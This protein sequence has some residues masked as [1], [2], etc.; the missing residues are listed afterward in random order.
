MSIL[1]VMISYTLGAIPFGLLLVRWKTGKDVRL[2]GSGRTGTTNSMRAAGYPVGILTLIL[3][4]LK[5]MGT[6][7]L[8]KW[9]APG[10]E[11]A[12]V[13]APLAAILGHNYSIFLAE[14]GADGRVRLR[15][16]A[17]GA[18]ALGGA[19]GLYPLNLVILVGVGLIMFFGVGYASLAT[20]SVGV[21]AT[22]VFAMRAWLGYSPWIY[23]LYGVFAEALLLWA[24][25][26]NIRALID[27]T[28][29]GVGWRAKNASAAPENGKE[30]STPK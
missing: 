8:A 11:W 15:G 20:M 29:R 26:P 7:W 4:M 18:P 3:D 13:G 21:T 17:G 9:L 6:V 19:V 10:I 27:G 14:R 25:R 16:G 24:L 22:I 12:L 2:V 28:E 1:V 30:D 23:V 5:G